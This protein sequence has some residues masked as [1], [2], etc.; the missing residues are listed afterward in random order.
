MAAL[1]SLLLMVGLFLIMGWLTA[2]RGN[3]RT[4]WLRTLVFLGA[5]GLGTLLV[6]LGFIVLLLAI[7]ALGGLSLWTGIDVGLFTGLFII[8]LAAG[9]VLFVIALP[10]MRRARVTMDV[11][12]IIEYY[13]QWLLIYVTIYQVAV[14][15]LSGLQ[16]LLGDAE[17]ERAMQG[18]L[19]T[20]LDPSVLVVLLLPVLIAV[21]ISVAMTKLRIDAEHPTDAEPL[22]L[23]PRTRRAQRRRRAGRQKPES[24]GTPPGDDAA[25][26]A[27][28]E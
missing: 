5:V 28:V 15:Q 10:I 26:A 19:S 24:A 6:L 18:Y 22:M 23:I 9:V 17:A 20:I 13:I 14:D 1:I 27:A 3:S 16:K 11:L 2:P 7:V 4:R 21:W 25:D 8:V 12:T